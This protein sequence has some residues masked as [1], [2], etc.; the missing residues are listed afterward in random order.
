MGCTKLMAWFEVLGGRC[1]LEA[2][3]SCDSL[4]NPHQPWR[5][6]ALITFL[7]SLAKR[8]HSSLNYRVPDC[9]EPVFI[10]ISIANLWQLSAC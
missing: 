2:K 1:S 3:A 10:N 7:V 4:A 5:T 9:G 8:K 6:D